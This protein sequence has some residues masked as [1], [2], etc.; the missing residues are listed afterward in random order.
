MT[1]TIRQIQLWFSDQPVTPLHSPVW[2][3]DLA[4]LATPGLL[5]APL[6]RT[7]PLPEGNQLHLTPEHI[8][9][10]KAIDARF[11][12]FF[13]LHHD[14]LLI[15]DRWLWLQRQTGWR[16]WDLPHLA[17]FLCREETQ[18]RQS[19]LKG[20]LQLFN[21]EQLR[22]QRQ[23]GRMDSSMHEVLDCLI[24]QDPPG[25]LAQGLKDSLATRLGKQGAL[26]E[27]SGG[28]DSTALLLSARALS[29]PVQTVTA[30]DSQSSAPDDRRHAQQCAVRLG[31]SQQLIDLAHIDCMPLHTTLPANHPSMMFLA[32]GYEQSLLDHCHGA[33][34]LPHLNGH[35]GDHLFL[36]SPPVASVLEAPAAQREDTLRRLAAHYGLPLLSLRFKLLQLQWQ[37]LRGRAEMPDDQTWH[38]NGG[39]L[40]LQRLARQAESWRQQPGMQTLTLMQ[41]WRAT[42]LFQLAQELSHHRLRDGC[43]RVVFPFFDR[44]ILRAAHALPAWQSFDAQHSRLALR[45]ALYQRYREPGLWRQSKGHTTAMVLRALNR[46]HQALAELIREGWLVRQ[47][48][49]S[50]PA[51]EAEL[52]RQRYGIGD[53]S[54][55]LMKVI[56]VERF[57][58]QAS[59]ELT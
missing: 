17:Y 13:C 50:W 56:A 34:S 31:V 32:L 43:T 57:L 39:S 28:L 3:D 26:L 29:I 11:P 40:R 59:R 58:Q 42:L 45:R 36:A 47:G 52:Q 6:D 51:L 49:L 54:P 20:I 16:E 48:L 33:S 53:I 23:G 14:T 2:P 4:L 30:W 27:F 8:T 12:L 38:S 9:L 44:A 41:H 7:L 10:R 21:G 22:L 37:T 1:T 19:P 46:H 18:L 55:L 24:P 35:G 5:S 15:G 25:D